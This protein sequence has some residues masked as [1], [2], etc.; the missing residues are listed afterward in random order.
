[1]MMMMMMIDGWCR[2]PVVIE[3]MIYGGEMAPPPAGL[4]VF[5]FRRCFCLSRQGARQF[6]VTVCFYRNGN[7]IC[8]VH[9]DLVPISIPYILY[10]YIHIHR[11]YS[12]PNLSDT[13]PCAC[14]LEYY[15]HHI[16]CVY[17]IIPLRYTIQAYNTSIMITIKIVFYPSSPAPPT[18]QCSLLQPSPV[19][20]H[21]QLGTQVP[22]CLPAVR[23]TLGTQEVS[24]A[25]LQT[26]TSGDF[27]VLRGQ[28]HMAL[29]I[30]Q[31]NKCLTSPP[32]GEKA[33]R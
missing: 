5:L 19:P 28:Q 27:G 11:E 26:K 24:T 17:G 31:T 16:P 3:I 18:P 25:L 8:R 2:L 9:T 1:M 10:I 4:Q 14:S 21:T 32:Q 20:A 29:Y 22:V 6:Q 15:T 23:F 33:K 13:P 30:R 7:Y 12:I